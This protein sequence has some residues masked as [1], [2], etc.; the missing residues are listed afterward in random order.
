MTKNALKFTRDGAIKIIA[1]YDYA[2]KQLKIH[3]VDSGK[4]ITETE[5]S[6]LF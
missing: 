2:S 3:V 4:G 1:A 5:M 6:K